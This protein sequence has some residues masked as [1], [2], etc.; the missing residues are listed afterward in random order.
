MAEMELEVETM[1]GFLAAALDYRP[2]LSETQVIT[3]TTRAASASQQLALMIYDTNLVRT[4]LVVDRHD[5]HVV[6]D[7]RAW[8]KPTL[9]VPVP[10]SLAVPV[11]VKEVPSPQLRFGTNPKGWPFSKKLPAR[12]GEGPH[13][14]L[15]SRGRSLTI[16]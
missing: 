12:V 1:V 3:G 5:L 14:G 15:L 4:W 6:Y 7:D 10:L 2:F 13:Q 16:L 11:T 9:A 8:E